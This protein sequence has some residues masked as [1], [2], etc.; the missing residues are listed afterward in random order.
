M[1]Y[2]EKG[3]WQLW[4][5]FSKTTVLVSGGS[6]FFF[7]FSKKASV[8]FLPRVRCP[9]RGVCSCYN[10]ASFW[11]VWALWCRKSSRRELFNNHQLYS[12]A[13]IKYVSPF[14]CSLLRVRFNTRR[15][16]RWK[17]IKRIKGLILNTKKTKRKKRRKN[18][19]LVH[20]KCTR[21]EGTYEAQ[22]FIWKKCYRKKKLFRIAN[23]FLIYI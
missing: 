3:S 17:Y 1:G 9:W 4:R 22:P 21:Y 16:R 5:G 23:Y 18:T 8:I 14:T 7:F 20:M 6:C 2:L 19:R 12:G 15:K 10:H 13:K 11:A